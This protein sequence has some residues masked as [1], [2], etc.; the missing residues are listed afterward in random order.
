MTILHERHAIVHTIEW[1]LYSP[2]RHLST[3]WNSE[4]STLQG[5]QLYTNIHKHIRDQAR[6]NADGCFSGVPVEC[7]S[8]VQHISKVHSISSTTLSQNKNKVSQSYICKINMSTY[9][10]DLVVVKYFRGVHK[11]YNYNQH[12]FVHTVSQHNYVVTLR[13]QARRPF[14]WHPI[15]NYGR[16]LTNFCLVSDKLSL[17]TVI[18]CACIQCSLVLIYTWAIHQQLHGSHKHS[19]LFT[20]HIFLACIVSF[21]I[22]KPENVHAESIQ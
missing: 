8:T 9:V 16:C 12:T 3:L 15:M 14:L 13:I 19:K 6:N 22:I 1:I 20:H 17:F 2:G 7:G 4:V 10:T 18:V 21:L 11:I 5:F